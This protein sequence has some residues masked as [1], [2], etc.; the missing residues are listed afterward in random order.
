MSFFIS[1]SCYHMFIYN[2][3]TDDIN[4]VIIII[5][6]AMMITYACILIDWFPGSYTNVENNIQ[7]QLQTSKFNKKSFSITYIKSKWYCCKQLC[8]I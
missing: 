2:N 3:N 1:F 6:L 4:G 8:T 7:V 5:D